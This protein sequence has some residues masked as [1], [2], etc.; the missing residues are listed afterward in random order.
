[1]S[2]ETD[3]RR[4]IIPLLSQGN[5]NT[6]MKFISPKLNDPVIFRLHVLRHYYR[7]G[8]KSTIDAF[9]VGKSTLYDWKK[10]YEISGKKDVSLIPK[11]TRPHQTRVMTLDTELVE[12]VKEMRVEYGNIGKAKIKVFLDEYAKEKEKTSYGTT[13]IG[14]IIKRKRFYFQRKKQKHKRKPLTLRVKRSPKEIFPGYIEMDTIHLWVLGRKYYFIT[15]LDIVT[16]FAWVKWVKS[17]TSKNTTQ[18]LLD[19]S[20]QY[21]YQ[22]RVVQTDNG[23]EFLGEFDNYLQGTSIKHEFIYPRSPQINGYIERFNRTL[24]EEFLFKEELDID[25]KDKFSQKLTN[26]LIWY[27]TKRPHQS[28]NMKSPLQHMQTYQ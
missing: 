21:K 25:D 6:L 20:K 27:N 4:F 24:K 9:W 8:W 1:M 19:L 12:F 28:L 11:S 3:R 15:A 13:K 2:H 7:Y 10:E 16:R 26:Y 14:L 18:A 17:P 22:L 23:S 5:Y